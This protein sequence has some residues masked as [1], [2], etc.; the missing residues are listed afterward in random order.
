MAPY[1]LAFVPWAMIFWRGRGY[2]VL[3][4]YLVWGG[5]FNATANKITGSSAYWDENTWLIGLAL[6]LTAIS[7]A[8]VLRV[9]TPRPTGQLVEEDSR[10]PAIPRTSDS[11]MFIPLWLWVYCLALLG[12][13]IGI[14]GLI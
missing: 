2:L 3:V 1:F 5:G 10:Y 11:F 7:L 4:F 9:T 8:L 13:G 6:I 14:L 12:I